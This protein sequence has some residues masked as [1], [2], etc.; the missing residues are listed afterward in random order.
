[1]KRAI[2]I[3]LTL[4]SSIWFIPFLLFVAGREV[5]DAIHYA[6]WE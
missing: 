5:M 1:M 2:S 6:L 3:L 4:T